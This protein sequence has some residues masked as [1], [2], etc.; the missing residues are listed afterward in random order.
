MRNK[1]L[2]RFFAILLPGILIL[3]GC[4]AVETGGGSN[5][6]TIGLNLELTGNIP[7]VG[8]HSR[9][10]A[11]MFVEEINAA[12]GVEIGG[13]SYTLSLLVED[14]NG[15]AEGATATANKLVT[16]DQVLILVGPNASVAAVPAGEVAN[17]LEAP[18]IS[19][20]STN[21]N[22][23]LN[24]PWVFRAPFLDPF[25][26]P[27]VANF[28]TEEFGAE[29]ACVLYDIASDY[30]TG[31]ASNFT[32]AWEAL[33][34]AGSV[35]TSESFTT[36]DQDFS[37]QLTNIRAADCEILFTPQ[38]YSEVPLIVEQ[39]HDLGITIPI[40]GSDSWGDP[41]LLE[42]CGSACDGYFF[43]T[44]YVAS[45]AVGATA[46]F[47]D[48]FTERHGEVPSDVGALTWDSMLLVVQALQN[49]GD[50]TGNLANDRA[51]VR[52]G[53]AAIS[54]FEG[55]TGEM[56]FDDQGD[57]IK[58]AMIVNIQDSEV[59]FYDSACP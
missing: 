32:S 56:V 12:G 57:P 19:P 24:R 30:P 48:K 7:K 10:A 33:H 6:L 38:Y 59:T 58:C 42:L 26:G 53:M 21:P 27:V 18:M 52:D 34:G 1:L 8:E 35:V 11:E 25:Q 44:H 40:V 4:Q 55:I 41:Q 15:T 37:A 17:N 20:W 13:Q 2:C 28:A 5:T 9:V 29:R 45:G 46:E 43:S 50:I 14:N 3:A 49:C 16:Q 23:T 36:G 51:C 54:D 31:L 47:I 39:A 22:T